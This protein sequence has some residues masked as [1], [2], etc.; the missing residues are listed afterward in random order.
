LSNAEQRDSWLNSGHWTLAADTLPIPIYS[1]L[2]EF[3]L[4]LFGFLIEKRENAD[5]CFTSIG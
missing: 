3:I 2:F 1:N 5:Q 4:N